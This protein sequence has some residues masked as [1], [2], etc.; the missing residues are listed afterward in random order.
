MPKELQDVKIAILTCPFEPPKPKTKHKVRRHDGP[1]GWMRLQ[2]D[3]GLDSTQDLRSIYLP[4]V[5]LS[6]ALNPCRRRRLSPRPSG[7]MQ[8]DISSVEG[9]EALR[10]Q[11][12]QYFRDMVQQCKD[13]GAT[14][15]ICQWG[16]PR[17]RSFRTAPR[18]AAAAATAAAATGCRAHCGWLHFGAFA[19][20]HCECPAL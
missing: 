13:S 11:E 15:I 6:A 4:P 17:C 1:V 9:F 12:Q 19:S 3:L 20:S 16:A 5:C 18:R 8:V 2:G 7:C 10:A 14:L